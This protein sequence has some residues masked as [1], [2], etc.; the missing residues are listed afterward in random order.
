MSL[1]DLV[2]NLVTRTDRF[3][4]GLN[5]ARRSLDQF[6]RFAGAASKAIA[7]LGAVGAAALGGIAVASVKMA[8]DM[9]QTAI[10]FEVM[11]GSAETA[12]T[13][14]TKLRKMGAATP[15][16]FGDLADAGK[17]LLAF[18]RSTKDVEKDL[19][20]LSDVA[21]GDAQRLASL[22]L[23]FGQIAANARLTGGDL[24]QLINTG[25]NPLQE[26]AKKTG[27]SMAELRDR[28]SKGKIGFEEVRE[29]FE[30]ATSAGGRFH[31]MNERM[32]KTLLGKWSTFKDELKE[33]MMELGAVIIENLDLKGATDSLS[34]MVGVFKQDLLP[35]ITDLIKMAPTLT[36]A[37]VKIGGAAAD[38]A[39][40]VADMVAE[41]EH[42]AFLASAIAHGMT[43]KEAAEAFQKEQG[44]TTG[45]FGIGGGIVGMMQQAA[46]KVAEHKA[47]KEAERVA[48]ME[49]KANTDRMAHLERQ[50]GKFLAGLIRQGMEGVQ[51]GM[52]SL[53]PIAKQEGRFKNEVGSLEENSAEAFEVLRANTGPEQNQIPKQQL[54]ESKKHSKL[55]AELKSEVMKKAKNSIQV[56]GFD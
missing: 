41:L 29:A 37:F 32:S 39:G 43:P 33:S 15:F 13:L 5:G 38:V 42:T 50:G 53:G 27:E 30:S 3:N 2:V 9:E 18:G 11:T 19:S 12:S 20:M 10:A 55:L 22:S 34:G 8:A 26:I 25:F 52:L 7:G 54:A 1:G 23:V 40:F 48:E 14:L 16:E 56:Q 4:R 46:P 45:R 6:T 49:A 24:L 51:A 47:A 44:L 31:K 35:V 17:T 28:M 36:E 21:A